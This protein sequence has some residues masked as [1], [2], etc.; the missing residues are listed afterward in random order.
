MAEP[1]KRERRLPR[2]DV[3]LGALCLIL[4]VISANVIMRTVVGF[5]TFRA[6]RPQRQQEAV[7]EMIARIPTVQTFVEEQ[8]ELFDDVEEILQAHE[9][10]FTY[11]DGKGEQIFFTPDRGGHYEELKDSEAFSEREK[12]KIYAVFAE[13]GLVVSYNS[14]QFLLDEDEYSL[15]N[16]AE[17]RLAKVEDDEV[18]NWLH[19]AYYM[20]EVAPKWYAYVTPCIHPNVFLRLDEYKAQRE[21]GGLV[22]LPE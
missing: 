16:L 3:L 10:D 17:L 4:C 9:Q 8:K 14:G 7:E 13:E 12:E 19:F 22:R 15:D 11:M 1:E 20:E 6:G 5:F 18:E 21:D 2:K